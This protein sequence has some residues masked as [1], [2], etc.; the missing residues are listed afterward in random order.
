MPIEAM[1]KMLFNNQIVEEHVECGNSHHPLKI[2]NYLKPGCT[3]ISNAQLVALLEDLLLQSHHEKEIS[4][5]V[6]EIQTPP[7][8]C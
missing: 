3:T 7:P 8:N 5:P 2:V 6:L 1:G 4:G